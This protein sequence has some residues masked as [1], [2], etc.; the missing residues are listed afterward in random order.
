MRIAMPKEIF[1]RKVSLLASKINIELRKKLLRCYFWRIA[2]CGSETGTLGSI[3][4]ALKC[5]TGKEWRRQ[6]GQRK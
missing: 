4:R 1:K 6:N 5:G 2:L 3:W